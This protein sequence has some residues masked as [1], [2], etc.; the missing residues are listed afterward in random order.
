[1][2]VGLASRDDTQALSSS[3]TTQNP[4]VLTYGDPIHT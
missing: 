3:P 1:M 2:V 4:T